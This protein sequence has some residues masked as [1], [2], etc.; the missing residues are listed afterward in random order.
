MDT[1]KASI[2]EQLKKDI[3]PLQGFRSTAGNTALD[4]SLGAIRYAFPA[5]S[6][7]L[8][9]MH[10]F[11]YGCPEDAAATGG[12]VSGLLASLM[13]GG[14]A[15]IWISPCVTIFP[16][17]LKAFGIS[18]EKVIFISLKKEKEILW[19]VEEALKCNGL[20]AVIGEMQGLSF[21]VSRRLQ[22]VVEQSRVTGFIFRNKA[23]SE[24]TTACVTRWKINSI[25]SQLP[26]GMPGVG[27]PRWNVSLLKI[28]NGKPGN[29][30]VEWRGGKFRPITAA[31]VLMHGQQ[32]KAV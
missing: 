5:A 3:L 20:A 10:E 12:F 18:P 24:N 13:L 16:P 8:G 28:R 27:F 17:A 21:T 15:A 2:I 1:S 7:P 31:S 29:W 6:F 11:F 26:N 32:K 14:G 9:S 23:I 22:L 25:S 19:A 30:Q 4:A